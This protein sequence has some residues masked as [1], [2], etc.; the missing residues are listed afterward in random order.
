MQKEKGCY[1]GCSILIRTIESTKRWVKSQR[2]TFWPGLGSLL[3]LLIIVSLDGLHAQTKFERESRLNEK[4]VPELA[5]SFV[6]SLQIENKVKWYL[7][8]AHGSLTIEAKFKWNKQRY[9]IEFDTLGRL[10]DVEIQIKWERINKAL[11]DS[12]KTALQ[13]DCRSFRIQKTQI[14]YSGDP[15][16]IRSK[17]QSRKTNGNYTTRYE[18]MVRCRSAEEVALYEYL[19]SDKGKKIQ[20]SRIVFTNSSHLEY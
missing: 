2:F 20:V 1:A 7:E 4:D 13:K 16:I 9:S 10:E 8:E 18:V 19:F 6:D 14:Q 5:L 11:R 15:S 12:M 17:L 3:C